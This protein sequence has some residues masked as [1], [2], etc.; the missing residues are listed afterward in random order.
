[1]PAASS[2]QN[3]QR[4]LGNPH[5]DMLSELSHLSWTTCTVYLIGR[6]VTTE[7]EVW[8]HFTLDTAGEFPAW[9]AGGR[10][11]LHE[12]RDSGLG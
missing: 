12:G 9:S 1:M 2:A 5:T 10:H 11:E 7:I 3:R 4:S 6:L 8:V